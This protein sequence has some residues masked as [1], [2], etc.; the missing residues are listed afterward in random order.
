MLKRLA[1]IL[2]AGLLMAVVF[3]LLFWIHDTLVLG[4]NP[5]LDLLFIAFVILLLLPAVIWGIAKLRWPV[6]E[7]F[8]VG[9]ACWV[10]WAIGWAM[11]IGNSTIDIQLHDTYYVFTGFPYE[12]LLP[13]ALLVF[14]GIYYLLERKVH[15]NRALGRLHFW[16]TFLG[17]WYLFWPGTYEGMTGLAGMPRRYLDFSDSYHNGFNSFIQVNHTMA[18]VAKVVVIMQLVFVGMVVYT[19]ARGRKTPVK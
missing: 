6:W 5:F 11:L 7:L 13:L 17:L 12:A 19:L 1:Y 8:A 16:V 2:V 4:L 14:T 15:V 3:W 9:C 10:W 18:I